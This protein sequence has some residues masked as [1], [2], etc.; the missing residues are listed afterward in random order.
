M[1]LK[2]NNLTLIKKK[3]VI[4]VSMVP[5]ESPELLV[6]GKSNHTM[7]ISS[8]PQFDKIQLR[9][10]LKQIVKSSSTTRVVS[11]T[12]LTVEHTMTTKLLQ[13]AMALM[14]LGKI[15]TLSKTLGALL[16]E[17]RDT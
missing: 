7:P 12:I 9:L 10:V 2:L 6:T 8:W 16:G 1:V 11:F 15:T 3:L 13:L 14:T 17:N 5:K 4:V